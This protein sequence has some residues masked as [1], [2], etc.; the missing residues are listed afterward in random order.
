MG[1]AEGAR[2]A[3]DLR[4]RL[5]LGDLAA[6]GEVAGE[7]AVADRALVGVQ[8]VADEV[9]EVA[10]IDELLDGLLD[11]PAATV[12]GGEALGVAARRLVT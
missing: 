7:Q 1:G 2:L 8:A 11:A 5:G 6:D 9:V 10:P 12:D 3:D 4:A